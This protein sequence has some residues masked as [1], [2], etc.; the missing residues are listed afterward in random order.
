[1]RVEALPLDILHDQLHFEASV[2]GVV[3]FNDV[4]V[5]Y[6]LQDRDFLFEGRE[7]VVIVREALLLIGF[8]GNMRA[9][10]LMDSALNRTKG[11]LPY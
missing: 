5:V 9:R 10:S 1:M 4:W 7:A 8:D 6:V 11:T 2:Q 3:E